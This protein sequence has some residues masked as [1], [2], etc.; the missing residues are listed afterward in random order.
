MFWIFN[1]KKKIVVDCF[2]HSILAHSAVPISVASNHIPDWWKDLPPYKKVRTIE[3]AKKRT[4]GEL[5]TMKGCYG[6][7]ELFK[8]GFIV[9]NWT[10]II[11]EIDKDKYLYQYAYGD[12]PG[13]HHGSQYNSES[14][15]VFKDFHHIKLNSP[16]LVREKTGI[17]FYQTGCSWHNDDN[18]FLFLPG[19][20]NYNIHNSTNINLMLPIKDKPY[21]VMLPFGRPLSHTIP[22][23]DDLDIEYKTHL[24]SQDEYDKFYSLH[25]ASFGRSYAIQRYMTLQKERE[26]KCPF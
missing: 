21:T 26:K 19:I 14:H 18:N 22:L 11:F 9:P 23:R 12:K 4:S 25:H 1:K 5:N 24:I 15:G 16:W 17:F 10:D 6:F 8:R 13:Q 2:T 7:I 20:N 3:D